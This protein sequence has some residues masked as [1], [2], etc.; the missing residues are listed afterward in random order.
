VVFTTA[1]KAQLAL[2]GEETE[3]FKGRITKLSQ[4]HL[5]DILDTQDQHLE[6]LGIDKRIEGSD[7]EGYMSGFMEAMGKL[8]WNLDLQDLHGSIG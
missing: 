4:S 3:L 1:I 7:C 2:L 6:Y 5:K 8:L